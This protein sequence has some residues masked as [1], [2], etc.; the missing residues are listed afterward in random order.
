MAFTFPSIAMSSLARIAGGAVLRKAAS[1]A[2]DGAETDRTP[3]APGACPRREHAVE[4]KLDHRR[5]ERDRERARGA[6]GRRFRIGERA[7]DVEM[8][9]APDRRHAE[10]QLIADRQAIDA[11]LNM[12]DQGVDPALG[13]D[14]TQGAVRQAEAG[15][16]A[17]APATLA[18][19]VDPVAPA[20]G[21]RSRSTMIV[22]LTRMARRG[23]KRPR[24]S[25]NSDRSRRA[26]GA[27]KRLT[28]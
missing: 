17:R 25:S 16:R 23:M 14:E 13:A 24:R 1:V 26:V 19:L 6:P 21:G 27:V 18:G 10:A 20:N 9:V 4:R 7:R 3:S 2:I 5:I 12:V 8:R 22:G 28:P 11:A 15:Q